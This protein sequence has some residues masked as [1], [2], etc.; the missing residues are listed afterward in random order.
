MI[1][2]HFERT[3]VGTIH[4]FTMDGHA[5]S[6]PYGFDLVCAG[7]SAVSF[8]AVNAI[9]EVAGVDLN[10]DM[11]DNGGFLRCAVPSDL[12]ESVSEKVQI[13]LEGLRI[14]LKTMEEQYSRFIHVTD[15]N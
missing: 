1:Q 13:L 9:A 11:R 5:D 10:V 15:V 3:S 8:G 2:V 6:G 4:S 7:A 14:S 12:E